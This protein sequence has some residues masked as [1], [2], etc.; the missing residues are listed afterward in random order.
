MKRIGSPAAGVFASLHRR[1]TACTER[2][3]APDAAASGVSE[4]A[5]THLAVGFSVCDVLA[6]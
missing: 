3:R 6:G 4:N 2:D 5:K 1:R